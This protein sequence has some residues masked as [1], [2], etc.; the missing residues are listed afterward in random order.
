M[1][2]TPVLRGGFT[3]LGAAPG[4][5]AGGPVSACWPGAGCVPQRPH[6]TPVIK[7]SP[8]ACPGLTDGEGHGGLRDKR[9]SHSLPLKSKLIL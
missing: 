8:C 6:F 2:T 4:W 1:P 5:G 9:L 7:P 3:V